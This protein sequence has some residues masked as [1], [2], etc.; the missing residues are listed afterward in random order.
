MAF[1]VTAADLK[2]AMYAEVVS[3]ITNEDATIVP[4]AIEMAIAEAAGFLSSKYDVDKLLG[5][6]DTDPTV[7][8]KNLK[9]KVLDI[10]V[11]QLIA[12]AN[13]NIDYEAAEA[14]YQMALNDYFKL[15]QVGKIAPPNWPYMSKDDVPTP[16][17]GNSIEI[18]GRTKKQHRF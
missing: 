6:A 10:V 3:E 9:R 15:V 7:T 2:F 4:E 1:L 5:T 17:D 13:P 12:L 14:R 11:W 16:A 18:T 8:D